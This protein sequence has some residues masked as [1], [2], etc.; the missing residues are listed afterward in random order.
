MASTEIMTNNRT[1][2]RSPPMPRTRGST[3]WYS[4][5]SELATTRKEITLS[6]R[7]PLQACSWPAACRPSMRAIV[8][9]LTTMAWATPRFRYL[10]SSRED[11]KVMG[12]AV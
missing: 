1:A 8:S 10:S 2:S 7:A 4:C 3:A 12:R 5:V 6:M 9:G 11:P